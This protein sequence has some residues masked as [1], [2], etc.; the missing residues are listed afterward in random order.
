MADIKRAYDE[1]GNKVYV[2]SVASGVFMDDTEKKTVA[3]AIAEQNDKIKT[4]NTNITNLQNDTL[5]ESDITN[6]FVDDVTKV[7]DASTLKTFKNNTLC[8]KGILSTQDLDALTE[9]GYYLIEDA[10]NITHLPTDITS[11]YN[12]SI[13]VV[14]AKSDNVYQKIIKLSTNEVFTRSKKATT[15]YTTPWQSNLTLKAT[16]PNKDKTSLTLP[17]SYGSLNYFISDGWCTVEFKDIAGNTTNLDIMETEELPTPNLTQ[18]CILEADGVM[19]GTIYI[20]G[21]DSGNGVKI[22]AH[23]NS[24]TLG[25]GTISYKIDQSKY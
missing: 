21:K 15:T 18:P 16:I 22:T 8:F 14:I 11:N 12:N 23:K 3:N 19:V 1:A 24:T 7:I 9:T 10:T 2:Y 4:I 6:D 20:T 13:V 25:F 5:T 17:N